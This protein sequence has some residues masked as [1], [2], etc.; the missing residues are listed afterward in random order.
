MDPT[1]IVFGIRTILRLA[2]EGTA[3]FN[4]YQRDKPALFPDAIEA[5]F[6]K[7]DFIRD[8][9]IPDHIDQITGDGPLAKFWGDL[10][11]DPNVPNAT[12]V[13]YMAAVQLRAE[14]A[15]R[16]SQLAPGRGIE[17]GGALMIQQ[18][19][20]GKGP[21]GPIGRVVLTMADIA[22]EFVGANPSLLG[23]GGNGEKLIGA[24]A[25][26]LAEMI[27]DDAGEFGTKSQFAE[28]L[29]GIVL[30]AGLKTLAEKSDLVVSQVHLQELLQKT[31][32]PIIAALPDN[33]AEQSRWRDVTD[34]LL[35]PAARAALGVLADNPQNFLGGG[36]NTGTA[37]GALT[38]ALLQEASLTGLKE[39]FTEAGFIAIY[40][41]ALGVAADRPELF[42]GDGSRP[43]Q[44]IA[45]DLFA[46]VASTLRG[47]PPPFNSDLGADLAII[48]LAALREH[49]L[50]VVAGKGAWENVLAGTVMQVVDGL[51]AALGHPDSHAIES[52]LSRQQLLDF[53]R[54][55]LIQAAKTPGMLTG[56]QPELQTIVRG[57][58]QAMAQDKNLLLTPQDWLSIATVAAELAAANPQRLFKLVPMSIGTGLIQDLLSVAAVE[59]AAG[60]RAL[61]GVLFGATLRDAIIMALQA[62]AGNAQAAIAH[63]PVLKTLAAQLSQLVRDKPDRYG[64]KEWLLLYRVFIGRVLQS[65]TL[66]PLTEPQITQILAGGTIA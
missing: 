36:F 41:A 44:Q 48:A 17:V 61:G 28:R 7:I 50:T 35:G 26:N 2:H 21:V 29:V 32:P 59:F 54:I 18:W 47:A 4:Q 23:L 19:A 12:E 40:Q 46:K 22:L 60:G 20:E 31:L 64:C 63:Q 27:P 37:V 43:S 56:D 52:L 55:F 30:Q 66:S 11:P 58:A 3:A 38:Q 57:V 15:A 25:T 9:F 62:A 5:D 34:A 24:L 8:T 10:V 33:L 53:A 39:L 45:A 16:R 6:R 65:G 42:V 1:L 51:K 13:L 49:G 14:M